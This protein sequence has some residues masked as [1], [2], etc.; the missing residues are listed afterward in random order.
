ML[1]SRSKASKDSDS[2]LVSSGW[3]LSQVTWAEMA[4][5]LLHLWR[6]SQKICNP[7]PKNFFKCRLEDWPIHLSHW[8]AL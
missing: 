7:Q 5:K 1:E 3:A 6:H 2:N 4:K 8:T